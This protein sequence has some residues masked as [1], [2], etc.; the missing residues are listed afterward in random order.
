[1]DQH[2]HDMRGLLGGMFRGL[3]AYEKA[4]DLGKFGA[5]VVTEWTSH[6]QERAKA[7]R[8]RRREVNLR[9]VFSG[10]A[11]STLGTG[12]SNAPTFLA[13]NRPTGTPWKIAR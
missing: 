13:I 9:R 8:A 6:Y 3:T 7:K 10:G 2:Q 12:M 1:M 11:R 5:K 4:Y